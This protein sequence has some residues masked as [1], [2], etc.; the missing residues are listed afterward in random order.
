MNYFIDYPYSSIYYLISIVYS[1]ITQLSLNYFLFY[2]LEH[3][4][5]I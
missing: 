2:L 4:F 1:I 3:Q 5:K